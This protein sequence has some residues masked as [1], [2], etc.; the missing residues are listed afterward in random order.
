MDVD[1][2]V[3]GLRRYLIH[4]EEY[5]VVYFSREDDPDTVYQAQLSADALPAGLKVGDRVR[6]TYLLGIV[7]GIARA[8]ARGA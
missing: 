3:E 6:V 2:I 8:E 5:V 1:A 4:A 7:A